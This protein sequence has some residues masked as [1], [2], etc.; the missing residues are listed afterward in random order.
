MS[1]RAELPNMNDRYAQLSMIELL[2]EKMLLNARQQQWEVVTKLEAER[3]ELIH[4]FFASPFL[5]AEAEH[6]ARFIRTV[7]AA[8][9][10]IICLGASEQKDILQN[11]QKINRGKEASLAYTTASSSK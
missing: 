7:L 9:R 6:V 4:A 5:L 8:D 10:E 3:S 1:A 11:S 2:T